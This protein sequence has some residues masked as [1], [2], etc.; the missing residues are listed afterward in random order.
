M[1]DNRALP[2]LIIVFDKTT[3]HLQVMVFRKTS[4]LESSVNITKYLQYAVIVAPP[5]KLPP[6]GK[7]QA[8]AL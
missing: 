5:I 8:A 6:S 2:G 7:W 1:N 3:I 4:F